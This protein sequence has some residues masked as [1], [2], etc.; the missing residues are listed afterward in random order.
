VEANEKETCVKDKVM[1]SNFQT[2]LKQFALRLGAVLA[3]APSLIVSAQQPQ[4]APTGAVPPVF[5]ELKPGPHPVGF[6]LIRLKDHTRL[7]RPKRDYFGTLDTADRAR[8]INL[9]VWYPAAKTSDAPMNFEQYIYHSDF[10]ALNEAARRE[11]RKFARRYLFAGQFSDTVWQTLLDSPMLARRN[12]R[13]AAG[14]F[15]LVLGE[16]RPLSN[17]ITNEY[18]ASHGYVVVMVEGARLLPDTSAALSKEDP[19][20]NLEFAYAHTRTM[21]NVDQNVTGT[22]GFSAF[23]VAQI[24]YAMRTREVDAVVCLES[25]FF[26][27]RS[28]YESAKGTSGFEVTALRAPLLHMFRLGKEHPASLSDFE[29][30]RYSTRYHYQVDAPQIRHAD[31][32]T[33]GMAEVTVLGL[34]PD[35]APLLRRAFELT[36]LYVLNFLNAYLKGDAAGLALLRR[37]PVAHGAPEKMV[38]ITEKPRIKAVPGEG[39]FL[40]LIEAQGLERALALFKEAKKHDPDAVLFREAALIRV[41]SQLGGSQRYKEAIEIYKLC[42]EAYPKSSQTAFNLGFAYEATGEKKLALGFFER[43]LQL[44][45]N[46]P[47]QTEGERQFIKNTAPRRISALKAEQNH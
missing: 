27:N 26:H 37:D 3:L 19:Y 44:V 35:A 12:A 29:A 34:R 45:E 24:I 32:S 10:G 39:E 16:L 5:G 33:E 7:V 30:M 22:L 25:G 40:R 28:L 8:Q 14:K 41:G 13:E 42:F 36:N 4:P 1:K 46:D 6:R 23:G 18:L 31:F 11:Q 15:P 20:R 9:H 38:S 47:N 43:S 17:S 21:P 2:Y